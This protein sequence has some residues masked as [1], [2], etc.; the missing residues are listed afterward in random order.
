MSYGRSGDRPLDDP[1]YDDP[2]HRLDTA[3]LDKFLATLPDPSDRHKLACANAQ[4]LY[5]LELH[6]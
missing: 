3:T 2:F 6:P 1:A 5:R 4:A